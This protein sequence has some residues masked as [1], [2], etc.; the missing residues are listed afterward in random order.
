MSVTQSPRIRPRVEPI[1]RRKRRRP[2]PRK[3]LGRWAL[4]CIVVA[5]ALVIGSSVVCK[6]LRPFQLVGDEKRQK[7]QVVSEYRALKKQNQ[8]LQRQLNY[9]K[10]PDGIAQEA[11]KQGFVKPGEVSLVIPDEEPAANTDH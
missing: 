2:I 4:R 1:T 7:A 11:R 8:E 6:I 3:K 5:V 10:T 9:L